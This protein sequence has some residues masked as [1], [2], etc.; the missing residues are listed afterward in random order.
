MPVLWNRAHACSYV[1]SGRELAVRRWRSGKGK[2]TYGVTLGWRFGFS[3]VRG[4]DGAGDF[5]GDFG[6]AEFVVIDRVFTVLG[7]GE[8]T[9]T[10]DN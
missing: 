7:A 9:E 8:I 3:L 10:A 2:V 4:D 5:N 6:G 1:R